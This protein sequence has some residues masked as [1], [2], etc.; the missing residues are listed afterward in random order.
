MTGLPKHNKNRARGGA[1]T[2]PWIAPD[3]PIGLGDAI[4][5]RVLRDYDE[6]GVF[7]NIPFDDQYS[8]L[9]MAIVSTL[10]AYGLTPRI[11]KER[12]RVEVRLLK[13]V[14]LMLTCK[15]GVT[16]LSAPDRMNMPFELGL[17]LGFGRETFL[18][19]GQ[20]HSALRSISDMNFCDVYYH[21]NSC[22]RLILGLSQWIERSCSKRQISHRI[23]VRR[24][25]GLRVARKT[26]G[27][28]YHKLRPHQIASL[29]GIAQRGLGL[30]KISPL[31]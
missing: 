2:L 12:R 10:T 18:M 22:E 25:E 1:A 16:D 20:E 19:S 17:L 7:L 11:A 23:L 27:E 8:L 5:D 13:I 4:R 28:D 14:E 26:L 3:S 24:F 21:E 9:E 29:L 30:R 6:N 31:R 15:Y